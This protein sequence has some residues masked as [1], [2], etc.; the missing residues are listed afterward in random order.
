[1]A[2]D[3]SLT[4][5]LAGQSNANT[6]QSQGQN[7][8]GA[9]WPNQNPAAGQQYPGAPQ[10]QQYPGAPQGQQYP[11]FPGAPQGQQFPGFPGAPAGQQYPGY[12]APGQGGQGQQYPGFP[13]PGQYPGAPTPGYPGAPT[14]GY[15]GAPTPGYPGAPTP[16]QPGA[17]TPGQPGAQGFP[18]PTGSV[19]IPFHQPMPSGFLPRY[20]VTLKGVVNPNPKRF[21]IDF[22]RGNDIALH[23]NPRFDEQTRVIVR[24]SMVNGKWGSEERE[25]GKFPFQPGQPFMLQVLCEADCY[26]VSANNEQLF[27]YRHKVRELKDITGFFVGGDI[28]ISDISFGTI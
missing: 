21:N 25:G 13:G 23:I 14:P 6:Q 16:G 12:P 20:W 3:F 24:N 7:W 26:K 2:D 27:Q 4:D 11:G 28:T 9:P 1:M 5:A 8:P 22:K 19:K 10:G 17:V 15:P 18:P